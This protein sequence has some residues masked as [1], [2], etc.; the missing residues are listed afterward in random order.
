MKKLSLLSVAVLLTAIASAQTTTT[1]PATTA[2]VTT[3]TTPTEKTQMQD[4]RK[5]IR[6]YDNKKAEA[7][8]AISVGNL[9]VAKTDLAA[10]K[11]DKQGIIADA[12]VLKGEGIAHPVLLADKQV[13]KIDTKDIKSDI[14]GIKADKVAE[15]QAIKAGNI[16]AAQADQ[17]DIKADR[18]DLKKDIKEARRD[19]IKHPVRRAR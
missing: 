16:T 5:D 19:G 8:K 3:T 18:K 11:V 6:A 14:T 7:K 2:P 10:A 13:K 9:A 15:Q 1:A 12:K 4:L 17:K